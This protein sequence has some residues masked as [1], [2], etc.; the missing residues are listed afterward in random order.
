MHFFLSTLGIL[1]TK[2]EKFYS[3]IKLQIITSI[4]V[5]RMILL[6]C[7]SPALSRVLQTNQNLGHQLLFLLILLL[8]LITHVLLLLQH[9]LLLSNNPLILFN[10]LLLRPLPLLDK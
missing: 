5:T 10:Y 8:L 7:S 6:G 9:M 2:A 1:T 4:G 3:E